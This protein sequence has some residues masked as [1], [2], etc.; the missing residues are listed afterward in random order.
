MACSS[1]IVQLMRSRK[2]PTKVELNTASPL[3]QKGEQ[4]KSGQLLK[5][6]PHPPTR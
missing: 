2:L 1:I 4:N 5:H 3:G 6:Q